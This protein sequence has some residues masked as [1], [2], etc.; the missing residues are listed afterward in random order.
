MFERPYYPP[1]QTYDVY[2]NYDYGG[3]YPQE[4]LD[5]QPTMPAYS[6]TPFDYYAK[7]AQPTNW[8]G[9]PNPGN[10]AAPPP[11]SN[12]SNGFLTYFQDKDGQV[13]LDKMLSTAGK[14]ANTFQQIAPL[15]KQ[16]SSF[17]KSLR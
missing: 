17:L 11:K 16:F 5:V 3:P 10:N 6:Y 15:V 12:G 13:D 1:Y 14:F 4:W 8:P 7:P 2:A 9:I